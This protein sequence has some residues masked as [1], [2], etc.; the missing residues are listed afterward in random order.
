[1]LVWD[2]GGYGWTMGVGGWLMTLKWWKRMAL[3]INSLILIRI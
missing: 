2:V 1:M 3:A